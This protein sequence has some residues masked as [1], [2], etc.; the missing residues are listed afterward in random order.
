MS[1]AGCKGVFLGIESGSPQILKNMNKA[2]TIE[3]YAV[4]IES[5]RRN[6]VLTFGSFITGFPGE[7]DETVEE[8]ITFIKQTKPDY[9][10]S[11]MWYCE[12]GTAIQKERAKYQIEGEGFVW[13]H[14]TMTSLDAM[15]HI[16]RM[17]LTIED[18]IWLP[19]WSFDFWIIPYLQGKGI[20]L[21]Q[22]RKFMKLA[23]QMLALEIASVP[24]AQKKMLQQQYYQAMIAEAEIWNLNL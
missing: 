3:K 19:Q 21:S 22:F 16:D 11:Q 7:T 18:S 13:K 23:K 10:R 4:G 9:Y 8:T 24:Q 20:T 2:A 6:G 17:F 14:A 12:P 15:D 5:L 1:E